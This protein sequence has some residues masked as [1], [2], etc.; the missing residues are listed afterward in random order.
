MTFDLPTLRVTSALIIGFVG[1]LMMVLNRGTPDGASGDTPLG[2]WAAALL[3]GVT[4]L[5][6]GSL[7]P[8]PADRLLSN[9]LLL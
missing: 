2:L 9:A 7:I 3:V 1:L 6:V 4:G 8:A 5:L